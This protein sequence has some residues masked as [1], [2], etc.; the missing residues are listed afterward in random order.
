MKGCAL[1]I[2]TV[3]R[4]ISSNSRLQ[5]SLDFP[6]QDVT[7]Y[8]ISTGA[9]RTSEVDA[10]IPGPVSSVFRALFLGAFGGERFSLKR[11]TTRAFT[12]ELQRGRCL[13]HRCFFLRHSAR[14]SAASQRNIET[15]QLSHLG[16]TVASIA[17]LLPSLTGAEHGT[18]TGW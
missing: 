7:T 1:T 3:L 4:L 5:T 9:F 12:Q 13:S 15:P 16:L 17:G 10:Y 11:H 2:S 8:A 14:S 18:D 6:W